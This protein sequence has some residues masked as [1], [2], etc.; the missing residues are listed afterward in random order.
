MSEH[1]VILV[2]VCEILSPSLNQNIVP[3]F[4]L[5]G[6]SKSLI[7]LT[8]FTNVCSC[9]GDD[10]FSYTRVI[11][12]PLHGC[13][14]KDQSD[15]CVSSGQSGRLSVHQALAVEYDF[16]RSSVHNARTLPRLCFVENIFLSP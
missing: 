10:D 15:R 7:D 4:G 13:V 9:S 5:C 16:L 14:F 2:C 6:P 3:F 8:R 12:R 11:D 1:H